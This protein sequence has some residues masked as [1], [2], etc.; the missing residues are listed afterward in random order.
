MYEDLF[1]GRELQGP[2]E[3]DGVSIRETGIRVILIVK[4]RQLYIDVSKNAL[5]Q[6]PVQ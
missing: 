1:V 4:S 5:D 6:A 2:F 3:P